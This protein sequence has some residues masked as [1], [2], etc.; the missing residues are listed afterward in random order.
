MVLEVG[1]LGARGVCAGWQGVK[2]EHSVVS[3]G[4]ELDHNNL[5]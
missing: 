5:G 1:G 3:T 2:T 4:A